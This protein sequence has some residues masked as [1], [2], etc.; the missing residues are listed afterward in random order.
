LGFSNNKTATLTFLAAVFATLAIAISINS[1]ESLL[2]LIAK[3]VDGT[4]NA[5]VAY[6]VIFGLSVRSNYFWKLL[7]VYSACGFLTLFT[8]YYA[9]SAGRKSIEFVLLA[10]ILDFMDFALICTVGVVLLCMPIRL[11]YRWKEPQIYDL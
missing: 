5:S 8:A 3:C 7:V 9:Y 10:T 2:R 1:D 6:I 11:Y 4:L